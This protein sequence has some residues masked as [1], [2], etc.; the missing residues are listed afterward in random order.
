[1]LLNEKNKAIY[2][3]SFEA[4]GYYWLSWFIQRHKQW[5]PTM[6]H[7]PGRQKIL[8]LKSHT[9]GRVLCV[10][11]DSTSHRRDNTEL[12]QSCLTFVTPW[13]TA[14]SL[15][16]LW[17]SPGCHTGVGCHALLQGIFPT[18]GSNP[19]LLRLLRW[20]VDSLA[21]VPPGKPLLCHDFD[22]Y[23]WA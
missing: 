6:S 11:G 9:A 20:Q 10:L 21:L 14:R 8:C 1:M 17:N 12:L 19:R 15:L 22:R 16:C 7:S 23:L 5:A 13:A 2:C 3:L 18:Q 4:V